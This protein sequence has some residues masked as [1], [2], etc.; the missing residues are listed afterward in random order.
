MTSPLSKLRTAGVAIVTGSSSGIGAGI[1][2]LLGQRGWA[3]TVNYRSNPDRAAEVVDAI[4]EAGGQAIAVGAD[5]THRDGVRELV[6]ATLAEFGRLDAAVANAHV[7]F[8]PATIEELD[9]DNL[10][11]K[12]DG[13]LAAVFHLTQ[14]CLP[15]MKDQG[16]GRLVFISSLQSHAAAAPGMAANGTGKAAIAA[17]ARYAAW[18]LSRHGVTVN[19]VSASLVETEATRHLPTSVRA[20][21]QKA[22]PMGRLSTTDDVARAVAFLLGE[23][24]V[25][26]TGIDLSAGGGFGLSWLPEV[27]PDLVPPPHTSA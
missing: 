10:R 2:R 18:E 16:T 1:A 21:M 17:F 12:V 26:T 4:K 8:R 20:A 19:V 15:T 11:S 6:R 5:A 14:G 24:G 27:G 22:T 9:F 3:V 7:P 25:F 13:E 23:D